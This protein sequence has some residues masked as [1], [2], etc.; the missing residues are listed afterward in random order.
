M[1][2]RSCFGSWLVALL[3]VV[4][5]S[6]Q[7]AAEKVVH[8]R[9]DAIGG[10]KV[11]RVWGTPAERGYAHGF[12]LGRDIAATGIAEFTA[13]FA[14][15][16]ALLQQARA[17]VGRLIAY[18]DEARAEIEAMFAG[19]VDSKA[20]LD[21]PELERAFDLQDLL[22]ANALDV[23]GLMGCSGFTVWGDQVVGGGVLTARNFDWPL[24]GRHLLDATMLVVQHFPDG[25]AVASVG[26]PGF[27][28]TVTGV[29][30]DGVAVFLHVGSAKI[31]MTPEPESWPTAVAAR[32]ILAHH[33]GVDVG[34]METAAK[35]LLEYTSPPAGFLTHV[36]VPR[37]AGQRSPSLIFETDAHS[38]ELAKPAP[39]ACVLTNHFHTRSDGRAASK[40]SLDREKRV[41]GEIDE[42]LGEGDHRVSIE[43]AWRVLESVQ[44]GGGHAFGTLHSLVFRHEPWCFELRIADSDAKG[45]VAAPVSPRRFVLTR[46]QVFAEIGERR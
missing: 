8:G 1:R 40:D 25:R 35:K 30:N 6:A 44:R 33:D 17:A 9:L 43:E 28:G 39:G 45:V 13:R 15:K 36:V 31:T 46:E 19:V 32:E 20:T 34:V 21:M 11:L 10:L 7:G 2:V 27:V 3:L 4:G 41:C 37:P 12:L 16:P 5:A 18:P 42:W 14:R 22:V 38:C 23:F 26:W 29:S 24:T